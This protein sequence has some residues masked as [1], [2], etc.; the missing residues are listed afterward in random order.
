MLVVISACQEENILE[1]QNIEVEN[2][3]KVK[4]GILS[5]SNKATLKKMVEGLKKKE[6]EGR[7]AELS[8]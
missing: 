7:N 3:I 1:T 5:F 4:N 8:E 2:T 6:V